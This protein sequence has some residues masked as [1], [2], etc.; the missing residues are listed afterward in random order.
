MTNTSTQQA[1]EMAERFEKLRSE[2]YTLDEKEC[3]CYNDPEG[4]CPR[5]SAYDHIKAHL[6]AIERSLASLI[7]DR[8]RMTKLDY[9]HKHPEKFTIRDCVDFYKER[10]NE[11]VFV[12]Q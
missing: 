12:L 10:R 3:H 8:E 5:C 6:R 7:K 9:F 1:D 2:L 4:H 11:M